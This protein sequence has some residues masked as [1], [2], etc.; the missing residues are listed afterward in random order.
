MNYGR[1]ED[2]LATPGEAMREYAEIVG[3][4]NADCAWLLTDYDVWVKNPHYRGP[5]Q[6][7]PE[8]AIY[9][10]ADDPAAGS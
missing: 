5:P 4:E 1:D 7:H 10:D 3:G 9:M 2:R 8:D 6:P